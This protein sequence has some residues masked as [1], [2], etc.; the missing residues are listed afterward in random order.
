MRPGSRTASPR[1]AGRQIVRPAG[2]ALLGRVL[3]TGATGL[4]GTPVR[5]LLVEAGHRVRALALPGTEDALRAGGIEVVLGSLDQAEALDRATRGVEIVFHLAGALPGAPPAVLTRTN[6]RGTANLLRSCAR[7]GVGRFVFASSTSV[8][9]DASRPFAVG[10]S[11]DSP[12]RSEGATDVEV[13]GLTKVA[14][15]RLILEQHREAGLRYAILRAPLVYG[16]PDGWDRHLLDRLRLQPGLARGPA[17]LVPSIQGV[18]VDDLARAI[19][20]AGTHP[21]AVNEA[22][23]IAAGEFLSLSQLA[24]IARGE[25]SARPKAASLKY[26][27]GKARR[28]L[29]YAPRL[30][31]SQLAGARELVRV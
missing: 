20:L 16:T 4:I 24:T 27:I 13:Y 2:R 22:F 11:E 18:H 21:K 25:M 31:L 28:L 26:D 12:L 14:A 15:E 23:N 3:V 30:S 10:I 1:P 19:V 7:S 8:Y 17:A 5:R 9:A 29:G 6:V